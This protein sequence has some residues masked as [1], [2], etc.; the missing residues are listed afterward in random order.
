M[1]SIYSGRNKN[2]M[3][4]QCLFIILLRNLNAKWILKSRIM[5]VFV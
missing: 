1:Y 5:V 2:K 3:N 4:Y